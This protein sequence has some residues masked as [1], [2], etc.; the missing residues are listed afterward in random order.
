[1]H[2]SRIIIAALLMFVS[3]ALRAQGDVEY[4]AEIGAGAGVVTYQG[5]L[6]GSLI[7]GMQPMG[8]VV[9]RRLFNP[10]M[11]LKFTGSYGKIKGNSDNVKTYYPDMA[12]EKFE[13]NNNLVDISA[14]YEYNFWPYGTG[15]DYRGAKRLTPFVF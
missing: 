10:Y 8:T 9:F 14:V 4:R 2:I 15:R 3:L 6:N 7:K 13:F 1:M 12:Q 11:G 5:D